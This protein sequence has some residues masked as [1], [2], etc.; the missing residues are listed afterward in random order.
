MRNNQPVNNRETLLPEGQFIYSRT[1]LNGNITEANEAFANISGFCRE[2]MIGQSHNL[3]RHPDMPEEAV[4]GM[5]T[6]AAQ[7]ENGVT[8]V[9]N[10]QN[11]LRE[12][13]VQMGVTMEMVSDISHSSS[14]QE[15]AMTVMA[16]GVERISSMTEQNMVVVNQTTLMVEQL[17][18]MVDRMEK[19]V[20][21]YSV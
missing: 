15:S 2:E 21:Q 9:Q 5:R 12:I 13:N 19:S 16:Q 1:D 3:V 4:A 10:A 20:T 8:L 18:T 7:V 14:E 6:G 11:A 17:N